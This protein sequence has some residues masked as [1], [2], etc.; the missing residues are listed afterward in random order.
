MTKDPQAL[1][2]NKNTN[3]KNT[4]ICYSHMTSPHLNVLCFSNKPTKGNW[5]AGCHA[6]W[7]QYHKTAPSIYNTPPPYHK[8][9]YVCVCV[10]GGGWT[11]S[12]CS[13]YFL[14]KETQIKPALLAAAVSSAGA[15][16]FLLGGH[17]KLPSD[18]ALPPLFKQQ[19]SAPPPGTLSLWQP[20]DV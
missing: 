18:L 9:D 4:L 10:L 15:L 16:L 6:N 3:I 2:I 20:F 8:T 17:V 1:N 12:G 13:L 7:C 14:S 5:W 19:S 11:Y